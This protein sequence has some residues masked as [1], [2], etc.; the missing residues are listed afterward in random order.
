MLGKRTWLVL[1]FGLCAA[2]FAGVVLTQPSFGE[3]AGA[4]SGSTK[5]AG[6]AGDK[7][8]APPSRNGDTKSNNAQPSGDSVSGAK[9]SNSSV[10]G[11]D[12]PSTSEV[13]EPSRRV[14]KPDKKGLPSTAAS[15]RNPHRRT[16]HP[17]QVVTVPARNSIGASLPQSESVIR[18]TNVHPNNTLTGRPV[19]G[20]PVGGSGGANRSTRFESPPVRPAAISVPAAKPSAPSRGAISGT[21]VR[22]PGTASALGGPAKVTAGI[23]G[24]GIRPKY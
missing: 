4:A 11:G 6:S 1:A 7:G 2:F 12:A 10:H 21:N 5:G 19:G 8:G 20:S 23:S 3:E 14:E 24:T 22:R 16:F 17:S 15:S 9:D 13:S 18:G